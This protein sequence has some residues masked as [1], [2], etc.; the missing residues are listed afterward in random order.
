MGDDL[1]T[2]IDNLTKNVAD[3]Q[4]AIAANAKAI[5]DLTVSTASALGGRSGSGGEHHQDRSAKHWRPEFPRGK[6]GPLVFLNQCESFFTQQRIMPEERTWMASYNLQDA[7]QLWYMQVQTDEGTPPWARF[8]ELLNLRFGQPL[9]AAPS[10]SSPPA[11]AR[12][13]SRSTKTVSKLSFLGLVTS[14][15]PSGCSCS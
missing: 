6:S 9:R 15:K 8:K 3:M 10:S 7:A 11:G 12:A 14:M 13:R 1:K 2:S 5:A 4:K